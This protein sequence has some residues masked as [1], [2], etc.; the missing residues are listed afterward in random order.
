MY[1]YIS[2]DHKDRPTRSPQMSERHSYPCIS[3]SQ[4]IL[5]IHELVPLKWSVKETHIYI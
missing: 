5:N 3:I 4:L 1:L 2:V